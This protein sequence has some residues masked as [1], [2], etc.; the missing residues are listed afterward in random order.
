MHT[1]RIIV[2]I[3]IWLAVAIS[4]SEA[5]NRDIAVVVNS[6]NPVQDL[7]SSDLRKI[8]SGEKRT[9]AGGQPIKLFVRSPGAIERVVLLKLLG[10]TESE[11]KQYWRAQV[12]RGE[13][14]SE[15]VVLFS[16]DVQREAISVYPGGVALVRSADVG[17]GMK[18]L[19]VNGHLP[20]EAGYPIK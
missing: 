5:Q 14:Q 20:G 11:F 4:F 10:M 19:R 2:L 7:T 13:S 6:K 3:A 9:W 17:D 16:N 18:V 8:F 1:K 12:F 15:P